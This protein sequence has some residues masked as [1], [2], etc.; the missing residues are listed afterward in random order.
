ML[1]R[2]EIDDNS[3]IIKMIQWILYY[4]AY[5]PAWIYQPKDEYNEFGQAI[6]KQ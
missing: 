1:L 5:I 4:I 3:S 6:L 2:G